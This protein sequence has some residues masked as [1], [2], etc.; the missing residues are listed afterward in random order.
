MTYS[1]N[2][3]NPYIAGNPLKDARAFFGRRD[4]LD[5]VNSKLINPGTNALVLFGQRRIGKTSLLFQLQNSLPTKDF[6]AVYID[7]QDTSELP[8]GR[9]LSELA[10]K[11]V[12]RVAKKDAS[13]IDLELPVGLDFDDDGHSFQRK[14]LPW[15][16]E[17]IG[18]NCRLVFLLDEFDVLDQTTEAE[19]PTSAARNSLLPFLRRLMNEEHRISFVFVIGRHPSDL[20]V[21]FGATFKTSL[22]HEIWV[23]DLDSAAKL[24]RQS[25]VNNTLRYTDAAVER[26][27]QLTSG[28]PYLI[29][30]LCQCI[31]DQIHM[32]PA[33]DIPISDVDDVNAT[34]PSAI[35]T[36]AH[37]LSWL[38]SG[39]Q[40][41]EQLY[42]AALAEIASEGQPITENQIAELISTYATRVSP[43]DVEKAPKDL[44]GHRVIESFGDGT[45]RFAIEL[46]RRWVKEKQPLQR[47]KDELDQV[48]KLAAQLFN[49]ALSYFHQ[50]NWQQACDSFQQVL[51]RNPRHFKATIYLGETL[52]ELGRLPKAVET[53]QKA[54]TLD[55][56]E[57]RLPLARAWLQTAQKSVSLNDTEGALL[58][59]DEALDLS[60][61]D[62]TAK[63]L[64]NI[65]L[66]KHGDVFLAKH[67]LAAALIAYQKAGAIKKIEQLK[68]IPYDEW[69]VAGEAALE[70][71]DWHATL[72]AYTQ[73]GESKI[74]EVIK[75]SPNLI[76]VCRAIADSYKEKNDFTQAKKY[77]YKI[78]EL[79]QKNTNNSL[80]SIIRAEIASLRIKNEDTDFSKDENILNLYQEA[81]D[82]H[83]TGAITL[84][85]DEISKFQTLKDEKRRRNIMSKLD[86]LSRV[87]SD[88]TYYQMLYEY[89][90]LEFEKVRKLKPIKKNIVV[91]SKPRISKANS[92]F[93]S[94]NISNIST[95]NTQ[96]N[97][98]FTETEICLLKIEP[99]SILMGD[100]A[101]QFAL[102]ALSINLNYTYWIGKY[103]VTNQQFSLFNKEHNFE[104]NDA[105]KPVTKVVWPMALKYCKWLQETLNLYER[106]YEFIVR[107]PDEVE[108]ERAARGDSGNI[109]PWGNEPANE[110][111]CNYGNKKTGVTSVGSYSPQGD[112]LFGCCDMAGNIWEWTIS[113]YN[114][115]KYSQPGDSFNIDF[116]ER[117]VAKGGDWNSR[118]EDIRCSSRRKFLPFST[119][120]FLGFRILI[121]KNIA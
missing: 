8:L 37:A 93:T 79:D 9:L 121:K 40:P 99:G 5:W 85:P 33:T 26:I 27:W 69:M 98:H 42:A 64:Q 103:P 36:G 97:I 29:Q 119:K 55:P 60:P 47:V 52:L 35:Q 39:L 54:Y 100:D 23:L 44:V 92:N 116:T 110:T 31:W 38:W 104:K 108:W 41:V 89:M 83:S 22:S 2:P 12:E 46:F 80:L 82:L 66:V 86:E 16:L 75:K 57:T 88:F 28:H 63:E 45:Y 59:C 13:L 15:F 71:E 67:N 61:N 101:N 24:I 70:Q 111:L 109:Y 18:E 76:T 58:A 7:L 1:P 49:V 96:L 72:T 32:Q 68:N 10:N 95:T 114:D 117:L 62:K 120:E 94:S 25:E 107:L 34:I 56:Q 14:F 11:S 73:A 106:E 78:K 90:D 105:L 77:L 115:K 113:P 19:L 53:F 112:S 48:D 50:H 6:L 87:E 17:K 51:Q 21:D 43:R 91:E 3:Y 84:S 102:P 74:V 30:L 118:Q 81:F 65:I 4:I 20:H